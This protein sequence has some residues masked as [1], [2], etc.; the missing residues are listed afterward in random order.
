MSLCKNKI[1]VKFGTCKSALPLCA[2]PEQK[3]QVLNSML[4]VLNEAAPHTPI[5]YFGSTIRDT[6]ERVLLCAKNVIPLVENHIKY[7]VQPR[8]TEAA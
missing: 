5:Y 7:L 3:I 8:H 4:D 2:S 1:A 6:G